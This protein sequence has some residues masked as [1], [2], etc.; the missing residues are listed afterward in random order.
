MKKSFVFTLCLILTAVLSLHFSAGA[1]EE[2]GAVIDFGES[3]RYTREDLEAAVDVLLAEFD[4]WEG[5]EMHLLSY[6]G[7]EESMDELETIN[8]MDN[9]AYDESVIF[10]SAFRSP[11]EAYGSWE[12]D[13]EYTWNWIL[14]RADKGDWQLVNFGWKEN[15]LKSE[16][17]SMEELTAGMEVIT[18]EM[19][20]MEGTKLHYMKYAGDEFSMGQL[21]YINSLERGTYDECAVYNVWFQSPKEAYGAWEADSLYSWSFYLGRADKGEWQIITFGLG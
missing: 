19:E 14:A 20:K 8:N 12:A 18:A 1:Q 11:K 3:E 15:Y 6:A 17:Y 16:R 5:C 9:S 10:D 2:S 13:E 4:T 7:D 21:E